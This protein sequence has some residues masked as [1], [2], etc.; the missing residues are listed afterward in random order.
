MTPLLTRWFLPS[1]PLTTMVD[2]HR[3]VATYL[4]VL[5]CT[6][7]IERAAVSMVNTN[8]GHSGV[9]YSGEHA[10][11]LHGEIA[12]I[13][14]PRKGFKQSAHPLFPHYCCFKLRFFCPLRESSWFWP[15]S[16]LFTTS[17]R[18]N[19][20]PIGCCA[21]HLIQIFFPILSCTE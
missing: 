21:V 8:R 19:L 11:K 2:P 18:T 6:T 5:R 20:T 15:Q 7:L 12:K 14:E 10:G 13:W 3:N 17:A 1:W 4:S 16:M 9:P